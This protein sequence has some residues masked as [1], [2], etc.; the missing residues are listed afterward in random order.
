MTFDIINVKSFN[1][2]HKGTPNEFLTKLGY[3]RK[4]GY[5]LTVKYAE[6]GIKHLFYFSRVGC[7]VEAKRLENEYFKHIR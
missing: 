3:S 4:I 6:G 2:E 1:K 7:D 5:V